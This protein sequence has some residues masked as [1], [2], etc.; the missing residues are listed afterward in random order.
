MREDCVVGGGG[1]ARRAGDFDGY[2]IWPPERAGMTCLDHW[3]RTGGRPNW[4]SSDAFRLFRSTLP[5]DKLRHFGV[6]ARNGSGDKCMSPQAR[7]NKHQISKAFSRRKPCSPGVKNDRT[8]S[9]NLEPRTGT[10]SRMPS[11]N[12]CCQIS[13]TK[14]AATHPALVAPARNASHHAQSLPSTGSQ[15]QFRAPRVKGLAQ[16]AQVPK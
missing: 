11:L 7:R 5:L 12:P 14:A 15:Q 10:G 6:F 2:C 8:K 16:Q 1:G 4:R 13:L 9:H 3:L